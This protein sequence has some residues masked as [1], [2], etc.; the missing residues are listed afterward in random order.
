MEPIDVFIDSEVLRRDPSRRSGPFRALIILAFSGVVR[1]HVSEV[2]IREFLSSQDL[3][4]RET[5]EEGKTALRAFRKLCRDDEDRLAIQEE[6]DKLDQLI[7]K[8]ISEIDISL[9]EWL[10]DA[11]VSVEFIKP[12]H[13]K[14]VFGAYFSG[15]PPFKKLKNR[16]D[17]PDAFIWQSV[18]D[19][20]SERSRVVLVSGDKGFASACASGP[21]NLTHC[22]SLEE[23]IEA[24][25]LA[26]VL[27]EGLL[28]SQIQL[29]SELFSVWAETNE[30]LQDLLSN[31]IQGRRVYF[32]FPVEA[33]YVVR[34]VIQINRLFAEGDPQY[35]GDG[36]LAFPFSGRALC[37]LS[38]TVSEARAEMLPASSASALTDL[39]GGMFDLS[40]QR[41]LVF[42]GSLLVAVDSRVLGAVVPPD[43]V[44][45]QLDSGDLALDS[46]AIWWESGEDKI[47][48]DVFSRHAMDEAMAQVS[49]GN[50]ESELEQLEEADRVRR[51][52]WVA[53]PKALQGS[54]G[55]ITIG[56]DARFK[57]APMP[58]FENWVRVLKKTL[59]KREA[60]SEGM[61]VDGEGEADDEK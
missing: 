28:N 23:L 31:E 19:L 60:N 46:L 36:L 34:T 12:D 52:R 9:R 35:Y 59:L 18:I 20:C 17:L 39:G 27:R 7:P 15:G 21:S 41:T 24:G 56:E 4:I 14:R 29:A 45:K 1:L 44:L 30:R 2:S 32:F 55:E 61:T 22:Q 5:A 43:E 54:H 26:A 37:D 51:A 8:A 6:I 40:V 53:V 13:A 50:L 42:F 38:T 10:E 49:A 16:D 48:H 25:E 47:P 11:E 58:R 57:I 3:K 33:D